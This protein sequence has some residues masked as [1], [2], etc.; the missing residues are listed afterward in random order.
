M[1]VLIQGERILLRPW[2]E[3][4]ADGLARLW[5]DG[6]V[7]RHVGFPNGLSVTREEIPEII[8]RARSVR[9]IGRGGY[10][11][12]VTDRHTGEFMGEAAVGRVEPD[13]TSRP[14]V[15]LLPRFW[16]QGYGTEVIRPQGLHP[17]RLPAGGGG[18]ER[19]PPQDPA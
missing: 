9:E 5:T 15:K 2:R 14:D 1:E 3:E 13:G 19:G 10:R 16:G 17:G 7:M 6:L 18:Q 12:A 4:D 11:L 8:V